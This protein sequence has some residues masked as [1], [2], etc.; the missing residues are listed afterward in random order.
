[1]TM[2]IISVIV[3]ALAIGWAVGYLARLVRAHP[4]A[5]AGTLDQASR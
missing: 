2:T 4:K 3:D 1:M 5:A